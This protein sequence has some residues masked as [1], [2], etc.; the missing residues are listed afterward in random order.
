MKLS[1]YPSFSTL[2]LASTAQEKTQHVAAGQAH[3]ASQPLPTRT[4]LENG[5]WAF[6]V[7]PGVCSITQAKLCFEQGELPPNTQ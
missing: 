7:F 6:A 5:K 1:E 2:C 4:S 3:G